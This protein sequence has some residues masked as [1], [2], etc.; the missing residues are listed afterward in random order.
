MNGV[1]SA[2]HHYLGDNVEY[3]LVA[4]AAAGG[5]MGDL[6]HVL[7]GGQNIGKAL[8]CIKGVGNVGVAD[9]LAVADHVVFD[10]DHYLRL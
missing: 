4:A 6:L 7:K 8:L 5:A 2:A 3:L 10:H 9:L 1:L